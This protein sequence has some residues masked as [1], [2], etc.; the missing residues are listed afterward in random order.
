MGPAYQSPKDGEGFPCVGEPSSRTR[1]RTDPID[2][3]PSELLAAEESDGNIE[4]KAIGDFQEIW[5]LF[6]KNHHRELYRKINEIDTHDTSP[7]P[8]ELQLIDAS[9]TSQASVSDSGAHRAPPNPVLG[10]FSNT[11]RCIYLDN[12]QYLL[13]ECQVTGEEYNLAR[14][15][16]ASALS[17]ENGRFRWVP[18]NGNF[19]LSARDVRL[20][21]GSTVLEAQLRNVKGDWM[22]AFVDLDERIANNHGRLGLVTGIPSTPSTSLNEQSA[23]LTMTNI[24]TGEGEHTFAFPSTLINGLDHQSVAVMMAYAM[25]IRAGGREPDTA[26][27]EDVIIDFLRHQT[28]AVDS[29]KQIGDLEIRQRGILMGKLYDKFNRT[30]N[31]NDLLEYRRTCHRILVRFPNLQEDARLSQSLK[32]YRMMPGMVRSAVDATCLAARTTNS[33]PLI[34]EA[35]S[36]VQAAQ[37]MTPEDHSESPM[38]K[39][40]LCELHLLR[41]YLGSVDGSHE[42]DLYLAAAIAETSLSTEIESNE[43]KGQLLLRLAKCKLAMQNVEGTTNRRQD[44]MDLLREAER[45]LDGP[46]KLVAQ[47]SLASFR[48]G[49]LLTTGSH[50]DMSELTETI[51]CQRASLRD[52]ASQGIHPKLR[53]DL[54][55]D[56]SSSLCV[57]LKQTGDLSFA[58]EGLD[59]VRQAFWIF[60]EYKDKA[61][62]AP[63]QLLPILNAYS[64]IL[65]IKFL[66][67]QASDDLNQAIDACRWAVLLLE[68]CSPSKPSFWNSLACWQLRRFERNRL[69]QSHGDG[70]EH[71]LVNGVSNARKAYSSIPEEDLDRLVFGSTL[72]EGLLMQWQEEANDNRLNEGLEICEKSLALMPKGHHLEEHFQLGMYDF[73][74][75]RFVRARDLND[76]ERALALCRKAVGNLSPD[77]PEA[78][79]QLRAISQSLYKSFEV[80]IEIGGLPADEDVR[81]QWKCSRQVLESAGALPRYRIEAGT[82]LAGCLTLCQ[83]WQEAYQTFQKVIDLLTDLVPRSYSRKDQEWLL[84]QIPGLATKAGFTALEAGKVMGISPDEAALNS[85]KLV[86]ASR[87]LLASTGLHTISNLS[88][89]EKLAPDAL[90]RYRSLEQELCTDDRLTAA[91]ESR[92]LP[93]SLEVGGHDVFDKRRDVLQKLTELER[94][95]R[96]LSLDQPSNPPPLVDGLFKPMGRYPIVLLIATTNHGH[97][98]LT[99]NTGVHQL[100]L[101]DL[102]PTDIQSHLNTLYGKNRLSKCA[103]LEVSTN[104][105]KLKSILKWLWVSAVKPILATLNL[106]VKNENQRLPRLWWSAC[107]VISRLPFHAAGEGAHTTENVFDYVVSSYTPSFA[108]LHTA[109]QAPP[110][111][112]GVGKSDLFL[113]SMP[114]TPGENPLKGAKK[115]EEEI[116]KN[117]FGHRF[118]VMENPTKAEALSELPISTN[119]HFIC[120]GISKAKNPSSSG[121]LLG[122]ASAA[123]AEPLAVR[124]LLLMKNKGAQIAYLSACSTA[125]N[126][127]YKLADEMIHMTST[128]LHAGFS[129]VIGTMWEAKDSA[130]APLAGLFY[131]FLFRNIQDSKDYDSPHDVVAYALHEALMQLRRDRRN[132]NPLSWA[133][134]IH[135]GA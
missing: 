48:R 124:D 77:H 19:Q 91:I 117:C 123:T 12:G 108:A 113:V 13:A 79:R 8:K 66:V 70:Y 121:L 107:G 10:N 34:L 27:L 1:P 20:I 37:E 16:L 23:V 61:M 21:E 52:L 130:A 116:I 25:N 120:H 54:L 38:L 126:S 125:E 99:T 132:K 118:R 9:K 110:P 96:T 89:L 49:G 102:H 115:E 101:P 56:F 31:L 76:Y 88:N 6:L 53:I 103:P 80:R 60:E 15:D 111:L 26:E 93:L 135:F 87:G 24:Q 92:E 106:L 90:D 73:L 85:L 64:S 17:N 22:T 112:I 50:I 129:H 51:A 2:L 82:S 84:S 86:E 63:S 67:T 78:P 7:S 45:Y 83:W 55:T 98:I 40:R 18:C 33:L 100:D 128:F 131:Q 74:I 42:D 11:S 57:A 62:L 58:T 133:P 71:D 119:V 14:L 94:E 3:P 81:F 114:T 97:A 59:H 65:G 104:N 5:G 95:F 43:V 28:L 30:G 122:R 47:M 32:A 109:R 69:T 72:G 46:G 134:F 29:K 36:M 41:Y 4:S 75:R 35:I 127:N 105:E 68:D 44:V 39:D